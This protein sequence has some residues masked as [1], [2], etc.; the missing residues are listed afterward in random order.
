VRERDE[1]DEM[2]QDTEA[3]LRHVC[4]ETC[5]TLARRTRAPSLDP[6]A[7]Y[8]GTE[9]GVP[10]EKTREEKKKKKKRERESEGESE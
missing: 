4:E 10:E 5:P 6:D 8:S 7:L 3:H 9:K 2:R 1:R